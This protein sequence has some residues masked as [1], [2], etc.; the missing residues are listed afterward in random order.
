MINFFTD[1]QFMMLELKE[2]V[3][4]LVD[5]RSSICQ[6][7]SSTCTAPTMISLPWN[8]EKVLYLIPGE[9]AR[10][11]CTSRAGSAA[12]QSREVCCCDKERV[13]KSITILINTFR[14]WVTK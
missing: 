9:S 7:H 1:L 13:D 2:F 4:K 11:D 6:L 12:V 8:P 14:A 5:D 3:K 10:E